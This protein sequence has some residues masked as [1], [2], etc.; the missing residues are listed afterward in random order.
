MTFQKNIVKNSC[1]QFTRLQ[2]YF[3]TISMKNLKSCFMFDYHFFLMHKKG[4]NRGESVIIST[5]DLFQ[6]TKALLVS[7]SRKR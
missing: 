1:N 5:D 4:P 2:I 6:S 3:F 7:F